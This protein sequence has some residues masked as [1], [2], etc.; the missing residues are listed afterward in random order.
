MK[1]PDMRCDEGCGKCCTI[2]YANH[3][4]YERIKRYMLEHGILPERHRDFRCPLYQ[5][6]KCAVYPV[7]P[8]LCRVYGHTE[9]MMCPKGYNVNLPDRKIR[10]MLRDNMDR[11]RMLMDIM[12]EKEFVRVEEKIEKEG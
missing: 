12:Y 4:E 10:K 8:L 6:G 5:N 1:L 9:R 2:T 11:D 3:S 7:R